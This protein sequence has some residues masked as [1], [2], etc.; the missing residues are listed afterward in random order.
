L[1]D[2][3]RT[4]GMRKMRRNGSS[5]VELQFDGHTI[6]WMKTHTIKDL[7]LMAF[8]LDQRGEDAFELWD[9]IND[10]KVMSR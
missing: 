6:E 10:L 2:E 8:E 4:D 9:L 1:S 5:L 3:S 7:K